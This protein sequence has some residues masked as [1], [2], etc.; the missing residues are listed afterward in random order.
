MKKP[1]N[2]ILRIGAVGALF[3]MLFASSATAAP[4]DDA[5]LMSVNGSEFSSETLTPVLM[6]LN[7]DTPN[8]PS[9]IVPGDVLQG[10]L[11]VQN[12]GPDDGIL[13]A[14]L[15]DINNN[16]PDDVSMDDWFSGDVQIRANEQEGSLIRW[17]PISENGEATSIPGTDYDGIQILE[18]NLSKDDTTNINLSVEFPESSVSGNKAGFN[19]AP[20]GIPN[21]YSPGERSSSFY[22]YLT[23]EGDTEAIT[24]TPEPEEPT[25]S[26]TTPPPGNE[27]NRPGNDDGN[28]RT[29]S[30][31]GSDKPGDSTDRDRTNND[32]RVST[33]AEML[34]NPVSIS[35]IIGGLA[36]AAGIVLLVLSRK[37]NGGIVDKE[38]E[39]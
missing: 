27:T 5:I 32:V 2:K 3:S 39:K 19:A 22:L 38:V 9:I 28:T 29:D 17:E 1:F 12:N 11:T 31:K 24:P 16:G 33:G 18:E 37:K 14:Y 26:S 21:D 6:S 34:T 4:I 25:D 23:L 35:A 13:N 8:E 7:P 30:Q 10:S 20:N 36:I 15:I